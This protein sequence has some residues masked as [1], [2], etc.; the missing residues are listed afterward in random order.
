MATKY[1][2]LEPVG[3]CP[4]CSINLYLIDGTVKPQVMPCG[5][6]GEFR[7]PGPMTDG[8]KREVCDECPYETEQERLAIKY[9]YD[10]LKSDL[11]REAG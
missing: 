9:S 10:W 5:I 11:H 6:G 8:V 3:Q 4:V 1:P 2:K 7:K